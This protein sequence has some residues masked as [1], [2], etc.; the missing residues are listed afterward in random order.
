M[1]TEESLTILGLALDMALDVA[2]TL[3]VGS[4]VLTTN[5]RLIDLVPV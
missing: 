4:A 3:G 5:A 2:I 1:I